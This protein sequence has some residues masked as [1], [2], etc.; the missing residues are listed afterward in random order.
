MLHLVILLLLTVSSV[1]AQDP[2]EPD[3]QP[4]LADVLRPLETPAKPL[5]ITPG[6]TWS[7]TEN[8]FPGG[9]EEEHHNE[10]L[11][12]DYTFTETDPNPRPEPTTSWPEPESTQTTSWPEPSESTGHPGS[13]SKP[14]DEDQKKEG[15]D[16]IGFIVGFLSGL[17]FV[18]LLFFCVVQICKPKQR[19]RPQSR[20]GFNRGSYGGGNGE[21]I[22]VPHTHNS[23]Y[24]RPL[25][26][27]N[28]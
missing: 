25:A 9:F 1:L 24:Q 26:S 13:T 23:F 6:E 5:N 20:N 18:V 7:T 11:P 2:N 3:F 14:T 12:P 16:I 8:P 17:V 4:D 19:R 27:S 22:Y 21:D 28:Y 10:T 15:I